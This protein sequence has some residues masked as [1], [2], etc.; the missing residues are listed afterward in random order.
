MRIEGSFCIDFASRKLLLGFSSWDGSC[1]LSI[2][3]SM[4]TLG[5]Q[6]YNLSGSECNL[7][8]PKVEM[9]YFRREPSRRNHCDSLSVVST[10]ESGSL[11]NS[12][13]GLFWV[14]V[15]MIVRTNPF[16]MLRMLLVS[17]STTLYQ[18]T[19][20]VVFGENPP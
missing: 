18:H 13:S 11:H 17:G 10:V 6:L 3:C 7:V 19:I 4:R 9:S 20:L 15:S 12:C 16:F 2:P 1:Q 5:S 14:L 8:V